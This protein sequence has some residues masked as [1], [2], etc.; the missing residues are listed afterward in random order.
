MNI[1]TEIIKIGQPAEPAVNV[2]E[3]LENPKPQPKQRS[4][5][6]SSSARVTPEEV[7]TEVNVAKNEK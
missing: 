2:P 3:L 6:A 7:K 4:A 1:A 5:V